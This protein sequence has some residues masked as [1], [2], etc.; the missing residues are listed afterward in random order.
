MKIGLNEVIALI[1]LIV[2]SFSIAFVCSGCA[3]FT[4]GTIRVIHVNEK[5]LFD[6]SERVRMNN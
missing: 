6:N 3:G 1:I 5:K 2:C 4:N